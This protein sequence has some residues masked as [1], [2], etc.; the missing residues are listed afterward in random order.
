VAAGADQPRSPPK[1]EIT[2]SRLVQPCSLERLV[3]VPSFAANGLGDFRGSHPFLAQG[4]DAGAVEGDGPTLVN[5]LCF[6]ASMP[7]RCRSRMKPSSIS[8]TMPSTVRTMCPIGPRSR[9]PA[10][11]LLGFRPLFKFMHNVQRVT[12]L[13]AQRPGAGQRS[14]RV[15]ST[16]NS[17]SDGQSA[18]GRRPEGRNRHRGI[19]NCLRRSARLFLPANFLL[20][21]ATALPTAPCFCSFDQLGPV[22]HQERA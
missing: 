20:K 13:R 2:A 21:E 3:D 6:R 14:L 19:R 8:A 9:W 1:P 18:A 16:R 17:P 5:A 7:A 10:P 15:T 22:L 11:A 12:R 4:D